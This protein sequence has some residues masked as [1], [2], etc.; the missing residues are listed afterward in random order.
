MNLQGN[1]TQNGTITRAKMKDCQCY[2]EINNTECYRNLRQ[3]FFIISN[4][5]SKCMRQ[6]FPDVK[7]KKTNRENNQNFAYNPKET[8]PFLYMKKKP[9][10]N[11]ATNVFVYEMTENTK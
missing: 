6:Q 3:T 8:K 10:T 9:I 2:F 7:I 4:T 5:I 11:K 1:Q